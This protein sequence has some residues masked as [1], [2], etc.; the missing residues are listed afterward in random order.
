MKCHVTQESVSIVIFVLPVYFVLWNFPTELTA[1][2]F[3]FDSMH[4]K[5]MV[6]SLVIVER[7]V[8][9]NETIMVLEGREFLP[10]LRMGHLYMSLKFW[11]SLPIEPTKLTVELSEDFVPESSVEGVKS[12]RVILL[13]V[14]LQV[15][16][17]V[18]LE[19][20]PETF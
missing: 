3:M 5:L 4:S 7:L 6:H 12:V 19:D 16:E 8:S 14:K 9:A 1:V 20:A 10:L 2:G 15:D 13:G 11:Q 17:I 18:C